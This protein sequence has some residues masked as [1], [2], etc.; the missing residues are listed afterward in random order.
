[1]WRGSRLSLVGVYMENMEGKLLEVRTGP[2]GGVRCDE[3]LWKCGH[4]PIE[5]LLMHLDPILEIQRYLGISFKYFC[6]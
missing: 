4:S 6:K 5:I 1:M 2:S 3:I